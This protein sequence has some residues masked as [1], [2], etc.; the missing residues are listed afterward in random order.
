MR[1]NW[2]TRYWFI[3]SI[4]NFKTSVR[5]VCQWSVRTVCWCV[6]LVLFN[7]LMLNW[8]VFFILLIF[9]LRIICQHNSFFSLSVCFYLA[10]FSYSYSLLHQN[11]ACLLFSF[12]FEHLLPVI[13]SLPHPLQLWVSLALVEFSI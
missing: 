1:N 13:S 10:V 12:S 8:C 6:R 5:T 4:N 11:C 7:L 3:W 2:S 9:L